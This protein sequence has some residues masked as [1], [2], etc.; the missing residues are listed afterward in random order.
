MKAAAV[1]LA[2]AVPFMASAQQGG[3]IGNDEPTCYSWEG[4]HK[5]A[6]SF[7]KCG[8]RWVAAAKPQPVP[9]PF[10]APPTANPVMVPMQ[11]CPPVA[12]PQKKKPIIKRK[13]KPVIC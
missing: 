1:L 5:S 4:G 2:L 8:P 6:G 3:F 10:A 13:P 12:T 11:S 7:H 9:A